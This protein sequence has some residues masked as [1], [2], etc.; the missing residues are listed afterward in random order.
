MR[1][2][3]FKAT[4]LYVASHPY[5]KGDIIVIDG[6]HAR[7]V[8]AKPTWLTLR[9]RDQWWWRAYYWLDARPWLWLAVCFLIGC[10]SAIVWDVIFR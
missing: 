10:L 9:W 5:R 4:E 7:V 2:P 1:N 6:Q 8:D 3:S